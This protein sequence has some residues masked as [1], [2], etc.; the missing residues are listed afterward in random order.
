MSN[1]V[2]GMLVPIAA[3]VVVGVIVAMMK[4][5]KTYL[6]GYR[7]GAFLREK[8]LGY[9]IPVVSGESELTL[10]ETILATVSDVA[11]GFA[12]GLAGKPIEE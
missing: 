10:K 6:L 7:F 1:F 4:R 8:G 9:D 12:R 11:R 3:S 2:A 5:A